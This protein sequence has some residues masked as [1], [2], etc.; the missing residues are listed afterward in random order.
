[1]SALNL[2]G[3]FFTNIEQF[4][5]AK[6]QE[7]VQKQKDILEAEYQEKLKKE[8]ERVSY[9]IEH[10]DKLEDEKDDIVKQYNKLFDFT[11]RVIGEGQELVNKLNY[12]T[13]II[14]KLPKKDIFIDSFVKCFYIDKSWVQKDF[15]E[16]KKPRKNKFVDRHDDRQFFFKDCFKKN[17]R[18]A[19]LTKNMFFEVLRNEKLIKIQK[20]F[21]NEL[22]QK[23]I[24]LGC[25][26]EKCTVPGSYRLA[27]TE[28][29]QEYFKELLKA[30]SFKYR[31]P[32]PL[33]DD[34]DE[35]SSF[36]YFSGYTQTAWNNILLLDPRYKNKT[37]S[38]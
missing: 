13:N 29:G 16:N 37:K 1:M 31:E 33:Y 8:Q 21:K 3:E 22:T 2:Q 9:W 38:N 5:Q 18:S 35:N 24:A 12:A 11:D 36:V 6:I 26:V 25:L 10:Y 7:E 30:Y 28:S 4:I 17:C 15:W 14:E 27:V 23:A 19:N 20:N 34:I 32:L